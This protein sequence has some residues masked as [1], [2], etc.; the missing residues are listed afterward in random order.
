MLAKEDDRRHQDQPTEDAAS[1]HDR[2]HADTDDVADSEILRRNVGADGRA[3]HD[4]LAV[5][6]EVGRVVG[7]GREEAQQVVVL[8][9][10]VQAAEAQ[11]EEDAAGKRSAALAGLENVGAG[12]ALGVWERAVLVHDELLAQ[13][14]HKEDAQPAAEERQGEDAEAFEVKAEKDQGRERE[15]DARSDGLACIAGGLDDVV[16][17]DGRATEDAQD[18]DGEDRDGD[19]GRHRQ[20]RPQAD[21][22]RYCTE[23]DAKHSA[24]KQRTN[25]QLLAVITGRNER[26]EGRCSHRVRSPLQRINLLRCKEVYQRYRST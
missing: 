4:L 9:E 7:R 18:G 14:N 19:A 10:R 6:V 20:T 11:A 22:D 25:A 1:K 3:L 12:R 26:A 15:D 23:D 13:R 5:G 8:E 16:F 2:G 17:K 24:Q 21:I